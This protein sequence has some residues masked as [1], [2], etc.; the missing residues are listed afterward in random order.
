MGVC[1]LFFRLTAFI[2]GSRDN[3]FSLCPHRRGRALQTGHEEAVASEKAGLMA[4]EAELPP[5]YDDSKN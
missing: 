5:Q 1:S 4:E 2:R 3:R